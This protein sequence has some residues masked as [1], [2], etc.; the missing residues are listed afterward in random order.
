MLDQ[1]PN[2]GIVWNNLG[3]ACRETGKSDDAISSFRAAVKFAPQM[4]EA[5]NNLGVAQDEFNLAEN[6][7]NSYRK[8]IELQPVYVSPHL[9]LGISL[10]KSKLFKEAE[11]H[12]NKVLEIQPDNKVARFML[13]SIGGGKHLISPRWNMYA[14]FLIN[15]LDPGDIYQIFDLPHG[16]GPFNRNFNLLILGEICL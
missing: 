12:Y 10:Q 3:V 15:V 7:L 16:G 2:A 11:E 8:A 6:A 14:I 9:N 5:C 1:Q 4:P 13:Q